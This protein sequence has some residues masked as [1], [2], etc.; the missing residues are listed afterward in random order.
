[1][2][3]IELGMSVVRVDLVTLSE[4]AELDEKTRAIRY[5]GTEVSCFYFR[6]GYSPQAYVNESCWKLR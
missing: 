1:M 5:K 2:K 4:N 6:T 3:L